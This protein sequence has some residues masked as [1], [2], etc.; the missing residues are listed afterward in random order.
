MSKI[1]AGADLAQDDLLYLVN[2]VF[3]PPKLPSGDDESPKQKAIMLSTVYDALVDFQDSVPQ[4]Q[5]AVVESVTRMLQATISVRTQDNIQLDE[6]ELNTTILDMVNGK[7]GSVV[8]HIVKQNAGVMITRTLDKMQ[9]DL[10]ELSPRNKDTMASAGRLRRYFPGV[11]IAMRM[12][13]HI[14]KTD[15]VSSISSMLYKLAS[16]KTPGSQPKV[17]KAGQF[18]GEERDTPSPHCVTEFVTAFLGPVTEPVKDAGLWKN[19]RD[20]IMWNDAFMPWRRS[21]LWL[22]LRVAM[23]L[24]WHRQSPED[25]L[26]M[27]KAFMLYLSARILRISAN[28]RLDSDYLEIMRLKVARRRL[29]LTS[30]GRSSQFELPESVLKALAK[31]DLD[32]DVY[33]SLPTLDSFL[34]SM[35]ERKQLSTQGTFNKGNYMSAF[36]SHAL[37]Y[38]SAMSILREYVLFNIHSVEA[39]VASH[40][41]D[42]IGKHIDQEDTCS[43]LSSLIVDYQITANTVYQGNP[44]GV[45]MAHLTIM[46]LWVAC[47]KSAIRSQPLLREYWPQIPMDLLQSLVLPFSQ[48]MVR[49]KKVELYLQLRLQEADSTLPYIFDSFGDRMSF[50]VRYYARSPALHTLLSQIENMAARLQN[51]KKQELSKVKNKYSQLKANYERMVCDEGSGVNRRGRPYTYHPRWCKKCATFEKMN[52]LEIDIYEWP[53]PQEALKAQSVVFELQLPKYFAEWRDATVFVQLRVFGCEYNGVGDRREP[54][55]DLFS[56][57]ALSRYRTMPSGA[58]RIVLSSSTKPHWRTHR[59]TVQVDL[60]VTDSDVCL[61]N[62]MTYHFFDQATS[63][64]SDISQRKLMDTMSRGCTYQSTSNA[65]NRFLY[66]PS[67]RPWGLSSNTVIANQSEAPDYISVSEFKALCSLPSGNKL[68]WQ[69]ILLQL[70]MPEVDFRKPETS[71]AIWQVMYQA[72]P[73]SVATTQDEDAG[74]DLRQDHFTFEDDTFCHEFISRLLHA[75]A[76]VKQNWE[77]SQALA[78]FATVATRVLS[79]SS[80]PAVHHACLDFL[81]EAR[82]TAFAWLGKIRTDSQNV[83]ED[84]R[85]ELMSKASEIGLICLSTFDMEEHHLKTLLADREHA[86]VFVQA[87]MSVQECL[88]PGAFAGGSVMNLLV[89]R[90]RKLCHR[91]LP[92]LTIAA[93]ASDNNP[94]DHAIHQYW[95]EYQEGKSWEPVRYVSYWIGSE[96]SEIHGRSLPVHYN[97]L[98]GELLVNGVPVS[99]VST[100]YK[101]HPTYQLLFGESILDVMPSNSPGMQFSVKALVSGHTVN[102]GLEGL[103]HQDLIVAAEKQEQDQKG[104][105][106][107]WQLVPSRVFRRLLPVSFVESHVHWYDPSSN[108]IEFRPL[109]SQW[110]SSPENWVLSKHGDRWKL[111]TA[112]RQLVSG[113]SGAMKAMGAIFD[114]LEDLPYLHVSVAADNSAVDIDLPR[115]QLGFSVGARSTEIFSRQFR[116]MYIDPSQAIDT[117]MGLRSKLIFINSTGDKRAILIPDGKVTYSSY[118][119]QVYARATYVQV[120]VAKGSSARVYRYNVDEQL[121]RL[122]DN[123][124]FRSKIYLAYL[125][126]LTSFCLPDGLTG[127]T[128]TEQALVILGS[129]AAR[130][131]FN[132]S[133]ADGS[134]LL[135]I[136]SLTPMRRFYPE[137]LMEMQRVYWDPQLG[138]LSQH[139]LFY[140]KVEALLRQADRQL[141]IKPGF[142]KSLASS[143]NLNPALTK[144]DMINCAWSRTPGFG[145]E[146]FTTSGD[147]VYQSRDRLREEARSNATLRISQALFLAKPALIGSA[148]ISVSKLWSFFADRGRIYGPDV[149]LPASL[150]YDTIW[151]QHNKQLIAQHWLK[152]HSLLG[153]KRS[154]FGVFQ[155]MSW[156]SALAFTADDETRPMI[157]VLFAIA[158]IPEVAS[159]ARPNK[160]SEY[161]LSAG[162]SLVT[163]LITRDVEDGGYGFANSPEAKLPSL[164]DEEEDDA[165]TRRYDEYERQFD[166]KI[167]AFVSYLRL[168]WPCEE[169]TEPKKSD[170]AG[171]RTY[172]DVGK[173]MTVVRS[174][175]KIWYQNHLF[176]IYLMEL[177][178]AISRQPLEPSAGQLP[179]LPELAADRRVASDKGFAATADLFCNNKPPVVRPEDRPLLRFNLGQ[180]CGGGDSQSP[181]SCVQSFLRGL[182]VGTWTN[183]E[184]R[185]CKDLDG[186]FRAL[187]DLDLCETDSTENGLATAQN[188]ELLEQ[189]WKE[190]QAHL[191]AQFRSLAAFESLEAQNGVL[192]NSPRICRTFFLCQLSTSNWKKLPVEW[193]PALIEFA[194]ALHD[195]QRARR[196]LRACS[197]DSSLDLL[198]ELQ[199]AAHSNWDPMEY[200]QALLMEVESDITIRS[201]QFEIARTMTCPP[202]NRNAV[203]QLNMGEGKSSVIVP[204]VA[205]LLADGNQLVRVI[206]AK[207]QSKQMLQ[208]LLAKLG[209]LLD[210]QV[211]QLPFSR[212]LRLDPAQVADIKADLTGCMRNGGILLVQPEHILSFKLMGLECLINGKEATGRYLLAGQRFFDQWSR[213]IVDESD[214]NFSVKFEL[215]YTMG[216]QQPIDYSPDR[217]KL[218]QNVIDVVRAV[219]PSVAQEMP[220]SLEIHNQFGTGSFPRLRILKANGQQALVDAVASRIC[221]TGL[222]G[223]P[224]ARQNQ[225]SRA[226]LLTYLTKANLTPAEIKAVEG[227][228]QGGLWSDATKAPLLLLRGI[229]AG[230]VLAFTLAQKRWKV[231]YGL[232]AT[233]QPPTRLAVPYRAKDSPSPRSEFSHPEVVLLLTSLSYY[234]GG[235]SDD[236]LFMTFGHLLKSDQPDQEYNAW[237]ADAPDIPASFR[238]LEGVNIK[239]KPQCVRLLFP[240]LRYAKAAIDYFLG[241]IVFPKYIK[242]FPSKLSVSGWDIGQVKTRPTS[243]FSGTNDA[244]EVLPLSVAHLD[245]PNQKHTN[246]L[247]LGYL[248]RDDNHVSLIPPRATTGSDADQLLNMVMGMQQEVQVLLDVGA[249]ILELGNV[250]VAKQWLRMHQEQGN[251]ST[252]QAYVYFND[253]DNLCV[254]DLR[255]KTELLQTSPF[256]TALNVCLVFLDE[257]HTR[258]TDLKLPDD[259][260]AAVTLGANLTKDRLVQACMRMR[261]LGKGQTVVFCIPPEIKVK[262]L[263]KVHKDEDE[264]IELAEVLHWAIIETWVDIQ[265]SIPLW[266]VQGRRFGHQKYLW[267]QSQNGNQSA[268]S[269]SPQQAVKFQEDEAQTIEDLYKPGERQTKPCCADASSHE[270]AS[271]IVKHC[272][273]FGEVNF[274]SAVLQEEQEREFAPEIEQERQIERPRPAKPATH[275]LDPVVVDFAKTGVLPAG[276]ASFKPAFESLELLTAAKLIPK[277]SEFPQDVLVTRDFARTVE[278]EATA[279]QDQ[280]LRPVQWVLTSTGGDDRSGTVKHLVIVSPFEAQ[281][282]LDTVRHNA[283]TTLHL[284]APRST[285]GFESLEDLRLYPTPALPAEWSVP[286]HLILQLNLFAGQLYISSFA[287]YTALC[288]MLGLDWEGGGKDGM[289]VCADGFVAPALNPGKSLKHSFEHSPVGFLKVYLTKVRRDCESIE[290]THMGKILNAVILRPE[291]F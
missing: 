104:R 204:L 163:D 123:G 44:E 155:L 281:N 194:L 105:S 149:E 59:K 109:S 278:L 218:M 156:F 117:L 86:S 236:D 207:P 166:S 158:S 57:E 1:K 124:N 146:E 151:L 233:R 229:L 12:E 54:Q 16:A 289:V 63:T 187:L 147:R 119:D 202:D 141:D 111:Q 260:R 174:R 42:W 10:F 121:G 77:S 217:W 213:D 261:K 116:G 216:T 186:S 177:V 34:K 35:E 270:G 32:Q 288:D 69:N 226:A 199:N 133:K 234:Y 168:Q 2:H 275:R 61:N 136:A 88:Q 7:L 277:L 237:V 191:L 154:Q 73:P 208:M 242:E 26:S 138:F 258:G 58:G 90:W 247:V 65:L 106:V 238:H 165:D 205:S 183:F 100:E 113:T 144:R 139:I 83:T 221:E 271:S 101:E 253:D 179:L 9:L 93:K 129:A 254:V 24:L 228:K 251:A 38:M 196:L 145:A 231:N 264:S 102:L 118:T 241:H 283:K 18:H 56:Y 64:K 71:F 130:S 200:P 40:L 219:A 140:Q 135:A 189:Y 214:E 171:L 148:D 175:W 48:D 94:F 173:I 30:A 107:T 36:P 203:M 103:V 257:A 153:M 62:G 70:S 276:S 28:T 81:S 164:P 255:G 17:K 245:L 273:Q 79:L 112:T 72:G 169:P 235:L 185:Y 284:Y 256:A 92:L 51:Q 269:M 252:K 8:L 172:M 262:I 84:F 225:E 75:C 128:G 50:A 55:N 66:R 263:Q 176:Y 37:P 210:V 52:S 14:G 122:V 211:L 49:L 167:A 21:P 114:A 45:S 19:T 227:V 99:R 223:L 246:A 209:G 53:L 89:A 193:K 33:H 272:A 150:S 22:L 195:L 239:D 87:C 47:D 267:D 287:D 259:Y 286:R 97:L 232:D 27:Y 110:T 127:H 190:C 243:G 265:R 160:T 266:A 96:T 41:E 25:G 11:A 230:G 15:F 68:Q 78:N 29:K 46:E 188:E 76:R 290:K 132:L 282:L 274:D 74:H 198:K 180:A 224:I 197:S 184:R 157:D 248:L 143:R 178:R 142:V 152:I 220:A 240:T 82:Q 182:K 6:C 206:V 162:Y 280:Y 95:P 60:S 181:S 249:Q 108:T 222:A 250:Q 125:H 91:A 115:L 98:T 159:V 120:V 134:L 67:E 137:G 192:V 279:K 126:G 13:D 285:L 215:V 5:R 3:L 20:E 85:Q 212:A 131:V 39:W 80:S 201:I 161:D 268:A 170:C 291:D 43:K 244:R 4:D 31:L 23:Q